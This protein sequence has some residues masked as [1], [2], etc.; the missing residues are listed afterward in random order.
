MQ[1][2]SARDRRAITLGSELARG[3]EGAIFAVA[4]DPKQVVKRYLTA[5]SPQRIEKLLAMSA[6]AT[7]GLARVAA[8]PTE[9]LVARAGDPP[10][11]AI[12]FVMPK[13]ASPEQLHELYTPKSR[14]QAFPEADF[15][16]VLHVAANVVRAFGA[17][18]QAG[19]VIG[20]VNHGHLLLAGDGRVTLIDCDSFQITANQKIF[21]CDVGV[22]LFTAPELHGRSFRGLLRSPN[23]DRFGLAVLLFHLLFMGRHPYSGVPLNNRQSAEIEPAIQAGRFAYGVKRRQLGVEQPPGTIPIET[24]GP[25][26]SSL[27]ER[28]FAHPPSPSRPDEKEWLDALVALQG[29][30][31]PCSVSTAHQYPA[32]LAKCPWCE[33]EARTGA[34][35]FGAKIP[36][37]A[38]VGAVDLTSLWRAIEGTPRPSKVGDVPTASLAIPART[39]IENQRLADKNV[40]KGAA[41]VAGIA[42]LV[43]LA[44]ANYLFWGVVAALVV[45]FLLWPKVDAA[46]HTKA[47]LAQAAALQ[48][49]EAL[50]AEWRRTATEAKFL[51]IE[52]RLQAAKTKLAGLPADRARRVAELTSEGKQRQLYLDRF[53]I[54]RAK[55][56]G[57]GQGRAATLASFGVETA[58][59]VSQYTVQAIPGFG[60]GLTGNLLAWRAAHLAR[61]RYNPHQVAPPNEVRVIDADLL[62]Q[63]SLFT[64]TLQSGPTD[65]RRASEEAQRARHRLKPLIEQRFIEL[66]LANRAVADA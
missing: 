32:H 12:A 36:G 22:P 8:W 49:Y 23:H 39:P 43:G 13:V 57:I 28:A 26:I 45:G 38:N 21:A 7:E 25:R 60:P 66:Q 1:L 6:T 41:A 63:R 33:I 17:V 15:R 37:P 58:W 42:A 53:R 9:L 62:A 44:A 20:D 29:A 35:L 24:F 5:P 47:K 54:D 61:F 56:S 3:G 65:L 2:F 10:A 59:D 27:F 19:H 40:R 64:A 52:K 46:V 4:T 16:F 51:E 50:V 48:K 14:A 30:I 34:R 18:H 31:K 55:I 11:K